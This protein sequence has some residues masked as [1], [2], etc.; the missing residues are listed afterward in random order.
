MFCMHAVTCL[1]RPVLGMRVEPAVWCSEALLTLL[2]ALYVSPLWEVTQPKLA[3]TFQDRVA[4]V[5]RCRH[6]NIIKI[7]LSKKS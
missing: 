1:G 3:A 5:S 4:L 7:L 6:N 2:P